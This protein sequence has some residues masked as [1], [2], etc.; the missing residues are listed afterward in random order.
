MVEE[1]SSEQEKQK[2]KKTRE[3]SVQYPSYDLNSCIE[4]VQAI[5]RLGGKGVAQGSLLSELGLKSAGTKSYTGRLSSSKQ[6]G[7]LDFKAGLLSITDRAKLILYPT[8]EQ[9]DLQKKKL[10]I[11][12]LKSPSLYQQLM[13]RFDGK[14]LP[15]QDTLANI[16]MNEYKIAKN[17]KNA[18]AKVFVNSA[19]FSGVL[20][21]DDYLQVNQTY[22]SLSGEEAP[23]ETE[24]PEGEPKGAP[25]GQAQSLKVSLS[26]GKSA[27]INVPA[28]IGKADVERLKKMLDLLIIEDKE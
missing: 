23:V 28:D 7:L 13:K 4:F 14:Q 26:N 21:G 1:K 9:K 3:K 20:G 6:F 18:A 10:T 8:E 15:K 5:D 2:S 24:V 11:E 19:K 17:A 16:L 22:A 25:T 12:A 27:T